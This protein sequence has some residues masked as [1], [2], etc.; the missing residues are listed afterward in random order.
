MSS[1]LRR[2]SSVFAVLVFGVALL[3]PFGG[4]A[5]AE[6]NREGRLQG[7][8]RLQI[9]PRNCQTGV[10]LAPFAVLASFARGGT[11]T[12]F[13][14]SPAFQPGQRAPGLGVWN[15]I[16]GNAY[17]AVIDAFILI[18]SPVFKRGVQRLMWDIEV[19]GNQMT[20]ESTSQF[21]DANGNPLFVACASATGTRFE[22][23]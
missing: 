20:I 13:N 12:E 19:D 5:A 11:L 23:G 4:A 17:R 10:P 7:T 21:F 14:A 1:Q 2:A 15:H 16:D 8:W 9:N 6:S 3:Q 18:D 22:E